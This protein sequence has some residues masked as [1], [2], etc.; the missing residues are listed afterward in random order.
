MS[1]SPE[2]D[3]T[4]SM[5]ILDSPLDNDVAEIAFSDVGAEGRHAMQCRGR[6]AP[7]QLQR[8]GGWYG[9]IAF[10]HYQVNRRFQ[11]RQFRF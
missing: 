6:Q 5:V 2:P 8:L 11:A 3:D 7:G 1:F 9:A 4:V 10:T